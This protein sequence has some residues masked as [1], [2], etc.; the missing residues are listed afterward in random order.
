MSKKTSPKH[1][2]NNQIPEA[3]IKELQD[4]SINDGKKNR[5]LCK[6]ALEI[7]E[8]YDLKPGIIGKICNENEIQIKNCQ[9]GCF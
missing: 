4:R 5:I 8:K 3:I 2:L 6:H 9:L 7:A 1:H